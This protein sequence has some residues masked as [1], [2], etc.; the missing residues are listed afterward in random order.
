MPPDMGRRIDDFENAINGGGVFSW[1]L[2][3]L[4][5]AHI[6][7]VAPIIYYFCEYVK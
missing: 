2:L 4:A 7:I 5:A 1:R 3:L 6:A